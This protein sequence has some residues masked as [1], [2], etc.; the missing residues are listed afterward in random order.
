MFARRNSGQELAIFN[1][2]MKIEKRNELVRMKSI[3]MNNSVGTLQE[4]FQ[5]E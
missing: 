5:E 4:W 1:F 2:S 3:T